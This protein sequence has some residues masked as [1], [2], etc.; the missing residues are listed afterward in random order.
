MSSTPPPPRTS[1]PLH[2]P[3]SGGRVGHRRRPVAV[4]AINGMDILIAA[5]VTVAIVLTGT[6][7][8]PK[9]PPMQPSSHAAVAAPTKPD[10]LARTA[11][12]V[13]VALT[14]ADPVD[15]AQGISITPAPGWTLGNRGP[16]W[17]ALNNADFSAQMRVTVK[18]ADGS[19]VVVVLQADINQFTSTSSTILNNVKNLSA[20][21]TKTLQSANFQQEAFIDYTADVLTQQGTIPVIGTFSELL[22]TSNQLSV[23]IDF[24]QNDNATTQAASDGGMMIHSM[25]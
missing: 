24:R 21:G 23:F 6:A 22:N 12:G 9:P 15:I 3:L 14:S 16:N 8:R 25:L 10:E 7:N 17:V 2:D 19:D 11:A 1:P 20:P 5:T 13:A 18:Q 4:A